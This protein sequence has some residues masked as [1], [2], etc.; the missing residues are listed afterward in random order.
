MTAVRDG[1]LG[2][3]AATVDGMHARRLPGAAVVPALALCLVAALAACGRGSSPSGSASAAG[4]GGSAGETRATDA[5]DGTTTPTV[6][7]VPAPTTT[8]PPTR[9]GWLGTRV[10][11]TGP[12]GAAAPQPTP[13]ELDPRRLP[14]V[15]TLP[16][17]A[18]GAYHSFVGPVPPEVAA[19]S[20]WQEACPVALD[21]LRY[22]TVSFWGFDDRAHTGELL[23]EAGSADG[24]TQ[25]FQRLFAARYPVEEMRIT[26][27]PELDAPPTGDG[28]NTSAFVCRPTRGS[29][30][31][32]QHAYGLAIDVN[33]FQNPYVNGERVLPELATSYLE[34]GNVRPGMILAGDPVIAA[35]AAIGWEWGGAWNSPTDTMHFSRDDR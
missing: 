16:P 26:S 11:P 18:D 33:P 19:R 5:A 34:R 32:S 1:R 6:P 23:V 24:M 3:V 13:P 10:L 28:N 17:P 12:D 9:P 4:S 22:V 15:D 30:R 20:T 2:P 27:R 21:D 29:T 7:A 25:V 14:T 35:F 31:W 8:P